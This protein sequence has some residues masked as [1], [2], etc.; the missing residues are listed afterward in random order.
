MFFLSC[1]RYQKWVHDNMTKRLSWKIAGGLWLLLGVAWLAGQGAKPVEPPHIVHEPVGVALRGQPI[2]ILAQISASAPIKSVLL[3][4]TLSKDASP[5]KLIMQPTGP[6]T[7]LGTIPTGLLGNAEKVS[8]YI[9]ATDDQDASAETPWYLVA[10]KDTTAMAGG[11]VVSAPVGGS[12][13]PAP[14]DSGKSS[15]LGVGL[16]AGGAAAV[17]GAGLYIANRNGSGSSSGGAVTNVQGTYSGN[18]TICLTMPGQAPS[19]ATTPCVFI[20]DQNNGVYS[21]SLIDGQVV[22][23]S[24]NGNGFTLN[25][26]ASSSN[27]VSNYSFNGSIVN[28]NIVGTVSGSAQSTTNSGNY[29]GSFTASK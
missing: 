21:D 22:S 28:N 5:F 12:S 4:Y 25:G 15:L 13:S 26:S 10:I 23:G 11:P 6:A 1:S 8:Y 14:A 27:V 19:C 29:S 24:L 16:I 7:F 17:I 9:E 18:K 20:V 3:H 2:T